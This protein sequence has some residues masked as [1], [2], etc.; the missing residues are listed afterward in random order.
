MKS[1]YQ[2]FKRPL[3]AAAFGAALLPATALANGDI[4]EHVKTYWQHMDEYAKGVERMDKALDGLVQE[5]KNGKFD[6]ADV[7]GL[8]AVWEDVD[9]HGAIEVVAM[10]LYGPIWE[11]IFALREA[12]E[13]KAP[14]DAVAAA[15]RQTSIAVHEGWGGLQLAAYLRENPEGAAVASDDP[16]H[17]IEDRLAQVLVEY[18]EGH[19]DDARKLITDA[20]FNHFE[21]IEGALIEQD[22]KLVTS[23]EEDFNGKLPSLISKGAPAAEVKKQVDAMLEKLHVAEALLEKAKAGKSKVF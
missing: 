8:I 15:A 14:A 19:A 17:S 5:A 3:I 23:L 10:P 4:G 22:P 1:A 9:V 11:G 2:A 12:A 13:Q 18:Q 16:I 7:E 21:G 6:D 20:Y